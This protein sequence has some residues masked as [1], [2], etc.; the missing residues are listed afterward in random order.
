M[1]TKEQQKEIVELTQENF[2]AVLSKV[3]IEDVNETYFRLLDNAYEKGRLI[4]IAFGVVWTITIAIV[5]KD[6]QKH[7]NEKQQNQLVHQTT[8]KNP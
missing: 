7:Q 5:I 6:Y 2:A 1:N 4:G 3:T 8:I